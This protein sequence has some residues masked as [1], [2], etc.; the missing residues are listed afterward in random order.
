MMLL[1]GGGPIERFC[2]LYAEASSATPT[3]HPAVYAGRTRAPREIPARETP[4]RFFWDWGDYSIKKRF[5]AI[6]SAAVIPSRARLNRQSTA[7][8]ARTIR[9]AEKR[10]TRIARKHHEF[11]DCAVSPD[12]VTVG[13]KL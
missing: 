13:K 3:S 10:I 6:C 12:S 4:E 5:E 9:S 2:M 1:L 8:Q 7:S 11:V